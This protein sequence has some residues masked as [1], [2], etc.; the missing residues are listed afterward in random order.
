QLVEYVIAGD[1]VI[2]FLI[3][4]GRV[5]VVRGLASPQVLDQHVRRLR[6]QWDRFGAGARAT[7]TGPVGGTSA[8]PILAA[9]YTL[10]LEPLAPF[11]TGE[12]VTVIPHGSLH[13][14]PFHTLFN[15][16][17]HALDRW[18]FAYAPSAAVWQTCRRRPVPA[19]GRSLIFG[20]SDP[21]LPEIAREVGALR[22]L[23]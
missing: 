18:E 21:G 20:V 7:R 5:R 13:G 10:L 4:R 15:G 1:E 8:E 3:D 9:L 2:A 14:V 17:Q 19:T 22:E 23:L 6:F 12:Q 16:G 11:L